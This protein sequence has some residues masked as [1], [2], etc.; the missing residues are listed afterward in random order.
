MFKDLLVSFKDNIKSK[1]RNPFLG[2]YL[3]IWCIRNWRLVYSFF[4]FDSK[5]TL[6]ERIEILASY[7]TFNSFFSDLMYNV[8]WAFG[9]LTFS[10]LLIN[11]S[12]LIVN[13]FEKK[14]TPHVY[15]MTDSDS[16]VLKETYDR[17]KSDKQNLEIK[18]EKERE[19]RSKMQ[20]EIDS[21]EGQIQE[22]YRA[23]AEKEREESLEKEKT[24]NTGLTPI[25]KL[26]RKLQEKYLVNKFVHTVI[27]IRREQGWFENK[28]EDEDV[29]FFVRTG[30]LEYEK[31][32]ENWTMYNITKNGQE[33][34]KKAQI[35]IE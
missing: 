16:I 4:Y 9:A 21:L 3:M 20:K 31:S 14:V 32:D 1:S 2:T 5:T 10:Y 29:K 17:L 35:E 7:Y 11:A 8:L 34:L 24:E 6:S 27:Q 13:F 22:M 19:S 33:V 15:K 25:D 23:S 18:L 30:L 28:N 12:R 26:Y